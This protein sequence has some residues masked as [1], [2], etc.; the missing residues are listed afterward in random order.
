MAFRDDQEHRQTLVLVHLDD[1][2]LA[3]SDAAEWHS[4]FNEVNDLS[5]YSA[6]ESRAFTQSGALPHTFA[7]HAQTWWGFKITFA[8]DVKENS[9]IEVPRHRRKVKHDKIASH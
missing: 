6:W 4:V 7:K 5:E 3:A 2:T 9:L 1:F 8:D